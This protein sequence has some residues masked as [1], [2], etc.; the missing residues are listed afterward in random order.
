MRRLQGEGEEA[1]EPQPVSGDLQLLACEGK[2]NGEV[3]EHVGVRCTVCNH[4]RSKPPANLAA[5]E[6]GKQTRRAL[7]GLRDRGTDLGPGGVPR[8]KVRRARPAGGVRMPRKGNL[9]EQAV[10]KVLAENPPALSRKDVE[11]LVDARLK[12]LLGVDVPTRKRM[13][14]PPKNAV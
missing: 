9:L 1:P 8:E 11:D 10:Q 5:R 6:N 13:G 2:C 14:R 12:E 3:T 4:S 7:V